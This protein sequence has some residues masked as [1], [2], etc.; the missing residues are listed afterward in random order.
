MRTM[1]HARA[2]MLGLFD[3]ADLYDWIASRVMWRL[4]EQVA[5]DVAADLTCWSSVSDTCFSL[6]LHTDSRARS[7]PTRRS[8]S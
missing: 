2:S 7:S 1:H 4:Y 6:L 5:A 3:R 8:S